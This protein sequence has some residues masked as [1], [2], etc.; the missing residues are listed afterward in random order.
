MRGEI[1]PTLR[2]LGWSKILELEALVGAWFVQI[3]CYTKTKKSCQSLR[4]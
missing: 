1:S 4:R 3:V 2:A